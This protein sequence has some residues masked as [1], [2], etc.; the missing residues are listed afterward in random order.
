VNVGDI[1]TRAKTQ[2]GDESGVQI[3]DEDIIR[4]IND[5]Q[6]NIASANELNQAKA[7]TSSVASQQEYVLPSDV[8]SLHSI[9]YEGLM[10]Q[11]MSLAAAEEHVAKIGQTDY[12]VGTPVAWWTWANSL[13]LYPTPTSAVTNGITLLYTKYPVDVLTSSDALSVPLT[14]HNALLEYVLSQAYELDE[15]W[16]ASQLKANQFQ[17]S[18]N[19]LKVD[20]DWVAQVT[21]PTITVGQDDLW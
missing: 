14:Y 1:L 6:R 4:W 5:G 2:F 12:N 19:N 10:L 7:T 3:Q 11:N 9:W 8:M 17:S 15:D 18:L 13:F 16:Q 20:Q 21:Y